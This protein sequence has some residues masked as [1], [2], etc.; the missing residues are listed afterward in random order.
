MTGDILAFLTTFMCTVDILC[1]IS[2]FGFESHRKQEKEHL[3]D[4]LPN[5]SH[6]LKLFLFKSF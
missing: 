2:D 4:Y 5:V 1:A 3:A 6:A